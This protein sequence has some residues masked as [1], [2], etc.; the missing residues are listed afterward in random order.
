MLKEAAM[1]RLVC[2]LILVLLGACASFG[3]QSLVGTY[4]IIS[5]EVVLDGTPTY[6]MGKA[7]QGCLVITPT[8]VVSFFVGENKKFGTSVAEKVALLDAL[9]GYGG[10]YRIEGGKILISAEA[11]WTGVYTGRVKVRNDTLSGNR[12]T[13]RAEPAPYPRDASKTAHSVTV[14]EKVE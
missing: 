9:V 2:G 14:W 8:R 7:P 11:S 6:P 4:K 1:A 3:Q 10:T 5:Q 13:L 12:L